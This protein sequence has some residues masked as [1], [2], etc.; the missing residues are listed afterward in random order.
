MKISEDLANGNAPRYVRKFSVKEVSIA[1]ISL[2]VLLL[3]LPLEYDNLKA[4][5][6]I[7][8]IIWVSAGYI[9]VRAFPRKSIT[10]SSLLLSLGIIVFFQIFIQV[11]GFCAW[12]K[13]GT[14]YI[15]KRDKSIRIICRT[16]DC[17]G[18]AEGCRLFEERRI[19]QHIKWVTSF[20]E[21]PIDTTKW[22]DVPFMSPEPDRE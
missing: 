6:F 4:K 16:Y 11:I 7:Y 9:V 18:T 5:A 22:Q 15:N 14:L 19:T 8:P 21:K 2:L 12:A 3:L 1:L 17:L 13:H 10:K 20:D